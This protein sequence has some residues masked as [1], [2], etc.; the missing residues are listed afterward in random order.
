MRD[1]RTATG[2]RGS[3][4]G[5]GGADDRLGVRPLGA[6]VVGAARAAAAIHAARSAMARASGGCGDGVG[7]EERLML[8]EDAR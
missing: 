5:V 3:G 1:A 7:V 6:R 2:G 4:G 8:L